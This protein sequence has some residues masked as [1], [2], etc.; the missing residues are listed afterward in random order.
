VRPAGHDRDVPVA[1]GQQVF[2]GDPRRLP[3]VDPDRVK[4]YAED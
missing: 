2:G 1:V 4:G 3:V